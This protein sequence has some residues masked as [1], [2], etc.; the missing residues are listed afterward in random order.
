MVV[1]SRLIDKPYEDREYSRSTGCGA[2]EDRHIEFVTENR[3]VGSTVV[4]RSDHVSLT[5]C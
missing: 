1:D 4:R 2:G 3:D 5:S